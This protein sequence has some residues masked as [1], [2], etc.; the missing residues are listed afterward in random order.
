[1][2]FCRTGAS[3]GISVTFSVAN[4]IT[5]T[6]PPETSYHYSEVHD[7]QCLTTAP[8]LYPNLYVLC[9]DALR[10]PRLFSVVPECSNFISDIPLYQFGHSRYHGMMYRLSTFDHTIDVDEIQD[11]SFV[12][13][14]TRRIGAMI[15]AERT[16]CR[17]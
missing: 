12:I 9:T 11:L 10:N 1:M 17:D 15:G 3:S 5:V 6:C 4:I 13:R 2:F 16:K 8:R 7:H 14:I